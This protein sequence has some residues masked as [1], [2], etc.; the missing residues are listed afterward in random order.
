V[1]L[2]KE[3]DKIVSS[4]PFDKIWMGKK[5]MKNVNY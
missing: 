1:L 4:S 5:W 3:A 2:N